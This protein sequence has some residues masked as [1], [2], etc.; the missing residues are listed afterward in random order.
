M[1]SFPRRLSVP[2]GE[3]DL[4]ARS[5][6]RRVRRRRSDGCES[7][8][9]VAFPNRALV[10]NQNDASFTLGLD[11]KRLRGTQGVHN[12]QQLA[13]V[14]LSAQFH[15]RYQ[16]P[17]VRSGMMHLQVGLLRVRRDAGFLAAKRRLSAGD[18][19]GPDEQIIQ[20]PIQCAQV[21]RFEATGAAAFDVDGGNVAR[22]RRA[23]RAARQERSGPAPKLIKACGH[24]ALGAS[25]LI[26]LGHVT[27]PRQEFVRDTTT[28][29]ID[30]V[31]ALCEELSVEQVSEPRGD[32]SAGVSRKRA[33]QISAVARMTTLTCE[34]GSLVENRNHDD[35]SAQLGR[36][37]R[38]RPLAE[39]SRTLIFVAVSRAIQQ[40][41]WSR[42]AGPDPRVES[43]V[44]DREAP[45]ME[46]R[47]QR[48]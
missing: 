3:V 35:G 43:H 9:R 39:Q 24:G 23:E 4:V 41:H 13:A 10:T 26:V 6:C 7:E 32:R 48:F 33:G 38:I 19:A 27:D 20:A 12:A 11:G 14:D 15:A 16:Q 28:V 17:I 29:Q 46:A 22:M 42:T 47:R 18:A 21:T 34:K 5:L 36:A 40:Q 45:A 25:D 31:S 1:K 30:V 44:V 37:P 8:K 2:A